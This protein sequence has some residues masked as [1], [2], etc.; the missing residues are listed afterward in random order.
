MSDVLPLIR[1][2]EASAADAEL[3]S[4]LIVSAF[5]SY[6]IRIDPPS[7]ALKETP[8]AIREKLKSHDAAIA[9]IGGVAVG[10]VLFAEQDEDVLYVGRLAVD[11]A[12]RRRGIARA[13]VAHAEA[14]AR[15]RGCKRLRIQVRIPLVDNQALFKSCG[16]VEV[17][18]ETHPGYTAPT[19]IRME[20]RLDDV[21]GAG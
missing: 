21:K 19:T 3:L 13:L 4:R 7:G 9:E 16:F 11:P 12:W 6:T 5:S 10:C 15:R 2:R 1:L 14:E 20:K 8:D 18:R 17:S